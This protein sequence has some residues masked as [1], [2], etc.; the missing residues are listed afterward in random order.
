MQG[1]GVTPLP[2]VKR[3]SGGDCLG[4]CGER[5]K[6]RTHNQHFSLFVSKSHNSHPLSI[7][8][9]SNCILLLLLSFSCF[10]EMEG[11]RRRKVWRFPKTCFILHPIVCC[12]CQ[13]SA[14]SRCSLACSHCTVFS[15]MINMKGKER[16]GV[17]RTLTSFTHHSHM[18]GGMH[19]LCA[20]TS[21]HLPHPNTSSHRPTRSNMENGKSLCLQLVMMERE[22]CHL[23][24]TK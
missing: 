6:T 10:G 21:L 17:A 9:C 24:F 11:E 15:H 14:L 2:A 4:G 5:Q 3:K 1:R 16:E 18:C 23:I 13:W 20:H 7:S 22:S 19:R 12:W 8:N